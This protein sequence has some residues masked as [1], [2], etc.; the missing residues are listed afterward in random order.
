MV[1]DLQYY[2][3]NHSQFVMSKNNAQGPRFAFR[4]RHVGRT[5]QQSQHLLLWGLHALF[6]GVPFISD[7]RRQQLVPAAVS[8]LSWWQ[9][10][11]NPD[12]KHCYI[13]VF[14][15]TGTGYLQ[16]YSYLTRHAPY[17]PPY[18]STTSSNRSWGLHWNHEMDIKE[19]IHTYYVWNSQPSHSEVWEF[20]PATKHR[21]DG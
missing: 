14:A 15:V 10:R 11:S 1:L 20:G 17:H 4:N 13:A 18:F 12:V 6:F 5:T 3:N 9:V 21:D 2:I 8:K 19:S 16:V 7:R